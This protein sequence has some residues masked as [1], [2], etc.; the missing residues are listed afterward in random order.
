MQ[1][2]VRHKIES[3]LILPV[4]YQHIL[5][6]VIYEALENEAGYAD[7]MHDQGY[8]YGKRSYKLFQFSQLKGKY[9]IREKKIIFSEEVS[10]EVRSVD[11]KFIMTLK[12][13]WK[14][15]GIHY[16]RQQFTV[17][18]TEVTDETVEQNDLLIRMRTPLTVHATDKLSKKTF[19]FKPD[20]ER[21]YNLV[22]DNFRRKYAAYT[23]IEPEED[24]EVE[25]VD[26]REKD[27]FVTNYKGFYISGWFGTYRL[28]GQRKYLDF[29]YQ[30]GLGERNS[31]GFGIH[32][33]REVVMTQP[34]I[35]CKHQTVE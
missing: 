15:K 11:W 12:D 18:E 14:E 24:I 22:K 20:S 19:F 6:A 25:P 1:L 10:F 31:Q 3:E 28:K 34:L 33:V 9:Q 8:G 27:K 23:G 32:E 17:V 16:G 2:K 35:F 7:R 21:F 5:Q 13:Y 26:V 30:S 29:L 4:K